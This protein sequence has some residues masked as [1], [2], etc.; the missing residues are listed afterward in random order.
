MRDFVLVYVNGRRHE[1]RGETAFASLTDFLRNELR[2]AGTKVVCAEGDCGACTVL[3]G[4]MAEGGLR[5]EPVDACIQFL[6]QLDGKHVI[7]VEGLPAN[8]ALHPVQQAMVDCHGS[9]CGFCTP[10]FIM[11]LAGHFE[12]Q[13]GHDK[14]DLRTAL[15]GNLCRCTGYTPIL[16]AG[17]S[18]Q[19]QAMPVIADRY[20]DPSMIDE[21]RRH[22]M[23]S[24]L[25]QC[26]A[27]MQGKQRTFFAPR[28]LQEAVD[29]KARHPEAVIVSGGTELGV[30]RNKKA[31]DPATLLSLANVPGLGTITI[32]DE[33]AAIGAN[34]TW[35]QVERFASDHAPELYKIILRFGSPQIRN[36]ATLVANVAHGSPIADSLPFLYV[37]DAEVELVSRAGTRRVN[38]N[39]FYRGYK[40]RDMAAEEI[41]TRVLVPLPDDDELLRLYKVSRRNDLDIATFGAAVRMRRTGDVIT[42]AHIAYAGVGPTVVRLPATE[43]LLQ[44]KRFTE[45]TFRQ[46]GRLAR[47]EIQPISDVRGSRDF[48][49]L[50]AKNVLLKFYHDCRESQVL[51]VG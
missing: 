49:L 8:G 44:G 21:L 14:E 24:V 10:G 13:N 45:E 48:R 33:G 16:D 7:T 30:L 51:A 1:I 36:V 34:V 46:A 47:D 35:T 31:Y 2:L 32:A 9:Q 4:R 38:I 20:N 41:I 29:F 23:E 37:M 43:A 26:A 28:S 3:V 42:R 12:R 18:L 19:A 27:T 6:Y 17:F 25:V 39:R 40:V 5:Y 22:A 15:T 11:A 50:L